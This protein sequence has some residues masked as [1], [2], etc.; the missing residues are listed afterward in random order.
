MT[1]L[2]LA[3]LAVLSLFAASPGVAQGRESLGWGRLF[4]N[5]FLGDNRDRWRTGSYVV[6]KVIGYGWDGQRPER[7]GEIVE[8][9]FRSE[10]IAP[11]N[12]VTAAPGDRRYVGALSFGVHTHFQRRGTEISLGG[13]LV[14]TGPQT[15]IGD[16][17]TEIHKIV[18]ASVPGVLGNQ[19]P[20]GFH[21]TALIEVGRTFRLSPQVQVRPFFEAQAGAETLVRAGGDVMIGRLGQDE[22]LLRDVAT[23]H[24]YRANRGAHTGFAAVFGADIAHVEHSVYLPVYDG[25]A[26]TD[27]RSRLRAG[28]H[29]QGRKSSAF[30]G[31][32]WLSEEFVSQPEGQLVGS[33]RLNIRF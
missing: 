7:A 27:H 9:R 8:F 14:I 20:D 1:R 12:I 28:V 23:G 13:D 18:G 29:W 21:P 24:R 15:G 33:V 25:I 16:L 31:L 6:S 22:L 30:Y 19:I 32:T 2:F 5:D 17:Q 10:T 26:L 4:T 3:G 11:E